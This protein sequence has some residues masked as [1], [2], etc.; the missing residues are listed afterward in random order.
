MPHEIEVDDI[1]HRDEVAPVFA[2]IAVV[3]FATRFRRATSLALPAT[4]VLGVR[5]GSGMQV[6]D[7]DDPLAAD[8][9]AHGLHLVT[10]QRTSGAGR[11]FRGVHR[12]TDAASWRYEWTSMP[13]GAENPH[14]T[15][16]E[17]RA[18]QRQ[19]SPTTWRI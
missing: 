7:D 1:P 19:G 9:V 17:L 10:A 14:S 8:V 18:A 13:R 4:T 2:T 16:G 11:D 12:R 15:A 6:D 5:H 3:S